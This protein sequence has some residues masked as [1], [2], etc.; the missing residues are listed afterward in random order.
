MSHRHSTL[1]KPTGS[2]PIPQ[3]AFTYFRV[4]N[5]QRL[6]ELV[7]DEFM[8]SGLSQAELARRLKKA[9]EIV[10]RL[11]GA[12][13]NWRLDTA[14]DLLFAI[15]GAEVSYGIAYPL[16]RGPRNDTELDWL[17]IKPIN[18]PPPGITTNPWEH[19]KIKVFATA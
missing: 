4:R 14:S 7:L 11:L 5:K 8:K 15:S 3:A 2:E 17:E 13:G 1:S 18:S 9:P 16:E 10:C 12:P 19:K 6:Y